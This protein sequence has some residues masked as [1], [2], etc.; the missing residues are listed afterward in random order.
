MKPFRY[1][2]PFAVLALAGCQT[3]NTTQP[4]VVGVSRSQNMLLPSKQI[5][6]SAQKAYVQTIQQAAQKGLLNRDPA[7]VARVR[8]VAARLIPQTAAFRAD[9]PGWRWEVNVI[10]SKEINA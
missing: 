3:V 6:D 5:N 8:A 2:L 1:V 4:G 10:S 7:T 9:A